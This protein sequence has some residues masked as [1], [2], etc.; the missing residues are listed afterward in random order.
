MSK[1]IQV[2]SR[3]GALLDVL[4]QQSTASLKEL[5]I[6]THLPLSTAARL[7]NSLSREGFVERDYV[8]KKYWLGRRFLRFV[9]SARPPGDIASVLHPLL[10]QLCEDTGEDVGLAELQ[11]HYAVFIDRVESS[12]PLRIID[13]ISRPEPLYCGAFRKILLA[14]QPDPWIEEYIASVEFVSYTETTIAGPE[15][16]W[17]E[18]RKIRAGGFATSFGERLPDAAGIAAPVFDHANKIRAAIQIAGPAGRINDTTAP[19]YISAAV[20]AAQ[21][22][23]RMLSGRPAA[24]DNT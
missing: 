17:A 16:L 19:G 18:I 5:S 6:A 20:Q 4:G 21:T 7:L 22:A 2:V 14:C 24:S 9:A 12:H 13:V 11:G 10:Q 15:P 1:D 23:T 8:T 3:V